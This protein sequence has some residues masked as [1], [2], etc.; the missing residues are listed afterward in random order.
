MV[1]L[2]CCGDLAPYAEQFFASHPS[3][4]CLVVVGCCYHRM[5]QAN[6]GEE[7]G[8]GSPHFPL[9]ALLKARMET[10]EQCIV[11]TLALRLAAQ[12]TRER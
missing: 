4:C 6:G 2:H 9:S 10:E 8:G 5:G 3:L 12:E 1:G 7:G 11:D